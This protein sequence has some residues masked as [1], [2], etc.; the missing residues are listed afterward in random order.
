MARDDNA[1][2]A[3]KQGQ[4]APARRFPPLPPTPIA[5]VWSP[6]MTEQEKKEFDQ[7]VK[8]NQLPF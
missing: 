4:K 5:G 8:D 7:Y 1:Q 2:D 3:P 6:K